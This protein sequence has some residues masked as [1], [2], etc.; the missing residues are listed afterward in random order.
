MPKIFQ[1]NELADPSTDQ[2]PTV[3]AIGDSWFWYPRNNLLQALIE[4]PKLK[5]DFK[6]IQMLG[7]NGA[8]LEEYVDGR[9]RKQVEFALR[10]QN[11]KHY[12]AILISGA[13]NDAV[14]YKLALFRDCSNAT[15]AAECIDQVALNYLMTRMGN[16]MQSLIHQIRLAYRTDAGRGVADPPVFI[17]SYDYPVADGRGFEL[18]WL[19]ITGPWLKNAMDSCGLANNPHLRQEVCNRLIDALHDAFVPVTHS[20]QGVYLVD[21]RGCLGTGNGYEDDWDNELHPSRGGFAKIVDRYWIP[22]LRK[23]A[24]HMIKP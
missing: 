22:V 13:G 23:H 17:H 19:N 16:A 1:P 6:W 5:D 9:Y 2:I 10:L 8:R 11:R 12:S 21:S 14:D 4:H 7:Y 20:H 15:T 3:L 24:P 18:T